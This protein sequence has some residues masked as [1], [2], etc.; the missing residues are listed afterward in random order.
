MPDEGKAKGQLDKEQLARE[1]VDLQERFTKLQRF[2][3]DLDAFAYTVAH[4]LKRPLSLILG[5]SE[6]LL[7]EQET[8]PREELTRGLQIIL[9]SGRKMSSTVDELLLLVHVRDEERVAIAPLD[10]GS[11]VAEALVHPG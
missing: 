11:I 6:L 1:L 7:D 10:M 9:E 5:F 4:D 3:G 8:I 2:C